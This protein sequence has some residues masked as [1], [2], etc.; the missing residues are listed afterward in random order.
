M[1]WPLQGLTM[2]GLKRLDDLQRCVESVVED[3]VPGDL[4][5]AGTWR[6]GASMLMRAT[7][8]TLG[9]ETRTV[10]VADSFQGFPAGEGR[11]EEWSAMEFLRV[12]AEEVRENFARLGLERGIRLH[13]GFFEDTLAGLSDRRW[14]IVRLDADTYESTMVTLE[15]LYP[16]LATGGYLIVDDFGA[17]AECRRAVGDFRERH[18]IREPLEEVDWTCVRWRREDGGPVDEHRPA[19]EAAAP[20]PE[21]DA[22]PPPRPHVPTF[23]ELELVRELGSLRARLASAE[24]ELA[25]LRDRPLAA[26][27]EWLRRKANGR[28]RP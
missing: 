2:V 15:A 19:P 27:A 14:A 20:D 4:I 11:D 21:L 12:P 8:D 5:E 17:L 24:K 28:T 25:R 9:D 13:P 18:G 1:D 7:L 23:R 3:E 22:T 10:W 26:P 16:G 6:G